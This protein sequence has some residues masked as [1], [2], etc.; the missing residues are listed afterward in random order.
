[1]AALKNRPTRKYTMKDFLTMP[2]RRLRAWHVY[3]LIVDIE[4]PE[5]DDVYE[6]LQVTDGLTT[7]EIV[8][9]LSNAG[10]TR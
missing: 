2:S 7:E 5:P 6:A 1:M 4:L 8:R 3:H 9:I 10:Y